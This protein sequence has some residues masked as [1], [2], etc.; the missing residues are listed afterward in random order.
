MVKI[1]DGKALAEKI[2]DQI[3]AETK[4]DFVNRPH[5]AVVLVGNRP[6]SE[7]YVA[8]K[9]KAAKSVGIDISIYKF[10]ELESEG[11]VIKTIE[12][13]N[14]DDSVSGILIQLP[15]PENF[16]TAKIMKALDPKKDVDGFTV[17]HPDYVLSPTLGATIEV[18]R[19][20][21]YDLKD[22]RVAMLYNSE[23]FMQG[24]K[25]YFINQKSVFL[26]NKDVETADVLITALG[27]AHMVSG[28]MIKPG[29]FIIDIGI[30]KVDGKVLGDV[31]MESVQNIAGYLTPVP[32]GVGPLTIAILLRNVLEIY[33]RN[34]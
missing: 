23:V 34:R 20:E 2:K 1:I 9:E 18:L 25:E 29:S 3:F 28:K 13:L 15:L 22:K 10:T 30:E 14:H 8:L 32:G 6:D 4:K 17:G 16:D 24:F 19:S 31:D 27:K 26:G 21:H 12:F 11:E 5:L 33:L 7:L